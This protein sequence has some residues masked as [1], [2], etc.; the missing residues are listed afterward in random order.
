MK[1]GKRIQSEFKKRLLRNVLTI[2]SFC[3]DLRGDDIQEISTKQLAKSATSVGANYCEAIHSRSKR[4][5][6]SLMGIA[7][8]ESAETLYWLYIIKK[9]VVNNSKVV[10]LIKEVGEINRILGASLKT[11]RQSTNLKS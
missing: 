6:A 9:A 8:R 3:K 1:G 4:E 7:F 2:L 11:L 10:S 5:F